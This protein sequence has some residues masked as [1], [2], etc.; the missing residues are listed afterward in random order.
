MDKAK[1]YQSIRSAGT[2]LFGVSLKQS[3]VDGLETIINEGIQRNVPLKHLAY[4]LATAFHETAHTMQPIEEYGKGR[5]R[6]YGRAVAPYMKAYYGRGY[7]QLT[8]L[9]NYKKASEELGDD[10]VKYPEKVMEPAHAA[11][12]MFTG[13]RDGWFTG[14]KLAD[15]L[16]GSGTDYINARRIINGTDRASQIA[17]YAVRFENALVA[18]GYSNQTAVP[19]REQTRTQ[20]ASPA[21]A[22]PVQ[23]GGI[24]AAII[25][26]IAAIFGGKK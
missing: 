17:G 9:S 26:I 14:K 16:N 11:E 24:V 1:F 7:V 2:Q 25:A 4:I 19:A 3:Q 15:Y 12:I 23:G 6:S 13:M 10:F 18:G 8:W 21:P 22:A 5:G 20:I